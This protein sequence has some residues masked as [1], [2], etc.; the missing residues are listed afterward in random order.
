MTH[1]QNAGSTCIAAYG[2]LGPS[3][4]AA[5]LFRLNQS[6]TVLQSHHSNAAMEGLRNIHGGMLV[7]MVGQR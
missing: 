3:S 5:N 4:A 6:L 7:T 2:L 1:E